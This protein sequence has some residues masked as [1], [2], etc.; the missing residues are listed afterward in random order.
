VDGAFPYSSVA[1][2]KLGNIFGTTKGN[3]S[4]GNYGA[5]DGGFGTVYKRDAGGTLTT[6]HTFS[7]TDG[8][9]PFGGVLK[10]G[11]NLFGTCTYGGASGL[12][13]IYKIVLP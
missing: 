8:A 7:D 10:K 9:N 11:K 2:D 4:S 5:G 1:V 13:V 3:N 6:L 12:G